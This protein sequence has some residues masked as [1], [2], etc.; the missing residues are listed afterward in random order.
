MRKKRSNLNGCTMI[1]QNVKNAKKFLEVYK[2]GYGHVYVRQYVENSVYSN[3]I[4]DSIHKNYTGNGKLHRCRKENLEELLE[5]Y[6]KVYC[7]TIK[8]KDIGH[9]E[10][11][12]KIK[13]KYCGKEIL[14]HYSYSDYIDYLYE[15]YIS[16]EFKETLYNEPEVY[17]DYIAREYQAFGKRN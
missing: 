10:V 3:D 4:M 8:Y 15:I 5:D 13:K 16:G 1:Y 9:G 6:K 12:V 17:V 7:D 2:N 14:T 11:V